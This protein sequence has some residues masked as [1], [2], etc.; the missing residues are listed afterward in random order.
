M[1]IINVNI[2]KIEPFSNRVYAINS[3]LKDIKEKVESTKRSLDGEILSKNNVQ[4]R[5][6]SI[7]TRISAMEGKLEKTQGVVKFAISEY[8]K[9]NKAIE[10]NSADVIK[11]H[12]SILA[13]FGEQLID[14][15]NDSELLKNPKLMLMSSFLGGGA[16]KFEK[17]KG[18]I[19]L[20]VR[21]GILGEPE[22][23]DDLKEL[24]DIDKLDPTILKKIM[25]EDGLDIY[26]LDNK[27]GFDENISKIKGIAC[28]ELKKG[29][30][31]IGDKSKITG[32]KD[33][34]PIAGGQFKDTFLEEIDIVGKVKEL[35]PKSWKAANCLD[36]LG[37][38]GDLVSTFTGNLNEFGDVND[39]VIDNTIDYAV[40]TGV[41]IL[42]S[43]ATQATITATCSA[44]GTAIVPPLGTIVG[45][46]VGMLT[47][48]AI[49]TEFGEPPASLLDRTKDGANWLVDKAIDGTKG[50][51]N[52]VGKGLAEVFW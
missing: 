32:M 3:S 48:A 22:L 41:D 17:V 49:N 8:D 1:S 44:I 45:Y 9:C 42:A 21:K 15:F 37:K 28:D 46:G 25:S 16:L 26:D 24:L 52:T 18:K 43:A 38:V 39:G 23:L 40:S 31:Y 35:N 50:A 51:V 14:A 2:D 30:E 4:G 47:T 19:I 13:S 20:K 6:N 36:N 33:I 7:N 27:I 12:T 34:I 10:K 11:S 29:L 5:F